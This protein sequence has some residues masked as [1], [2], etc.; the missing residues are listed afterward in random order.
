MEPMTPMI[1]FLATMLGG[2][3]SASDAPWRATAQQARYVTDA[4]V[5]DATRGLDRLPKAER[6]RADALLAALAATD[7]SPAGLRA[8]ADR[9]AAGLPTFAEPNS[10]VVGDD[11]QISAVAGA[12]LCL[13]QGLVNQAGQAAAK[14]PDAADQATALLT[15]VRGLT[16]FR[17]AELAS[18]TEELRAGLGGELYVG[19]LKAT[20]GG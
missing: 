5:Q 14:A 18:L 4:M 12:A 16:V 20:S 13:F 6:A 2:C 15:T 8:A 17:A 1:A 9:L 3:A 7:P 10:T 11:P 19:A